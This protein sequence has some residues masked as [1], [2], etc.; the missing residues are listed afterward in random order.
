MKLLAALGFA[1]VLFIIRF[2]GWPFLIVSFSL[3]HLVG[4]RAQVAFANSPAK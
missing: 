1:M 2:D 4:R 3:G